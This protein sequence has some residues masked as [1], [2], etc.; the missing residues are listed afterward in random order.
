MLYEKNS[1]P[2]QDSKFLIVSNTGIWS[3]TYK[4]EERKNMSHEKTEFKDR[5]SQP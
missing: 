5:L 1:M 2:V 4:F 3:P